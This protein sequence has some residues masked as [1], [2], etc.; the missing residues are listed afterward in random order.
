ME[1]T[2]RCQKCSETKDVKKFSKDSK[3]KDGLQTWCKACSAAHSKIYYQKHAKK[4]RKQSNSAYKLRKARNKQWVR[5][6]LEKHPCVDC[7]TGDVRVLEFD[8]CRGVK[9]QYV[10]RLVMDG[11][12][13][14]CIKTEIAKC[15]VVC[16]N[17][18]RIRTYE[19]D[20]GNYRTV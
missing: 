19:R 14:E 2:K 8:H 20:G 15:D 5:N 16:A 7:G 13:I 12:S 10:S 9:K 11:Y 6:F 17:C 3:Q 4:M 18:H 1:N